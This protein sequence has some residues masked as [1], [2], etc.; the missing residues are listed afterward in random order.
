MNVILKRKNQSIHRGVLDRLEGVFLLHEVYP[1][2]I[3]SG[4]LLQKPV[5]VR[6]HVMRAVQKPVGNGNRCHSL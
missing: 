4:I 1:T 3:I 2:V 6:F 5:N